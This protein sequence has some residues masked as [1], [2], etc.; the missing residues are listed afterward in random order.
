MKNTK[1]QKKGEGGTRRPGA[2]G[3]PYLSVA[4]EVITGA[5]EWGCADAER[6]VTWPKVNGNFRLS[7]V[8]FRFLSRRHLAFGQ[9]TRVSSPKAHAFGYKMTIADLSFP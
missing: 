3:K 7:V 8:D 9:T 6:G 1:P 2:L 4:K 5:P